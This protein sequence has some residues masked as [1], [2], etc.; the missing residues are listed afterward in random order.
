MKLFVTTRSMAANF[1]GLDRL[2]IALATGIG[3]RFV[4]FLALAASL[5][6]SNRLFSPA[7]LSSIGGAI[8]TIGFLLRP[9]ARGA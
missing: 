9:F 3:G 6:I 5:A 7:F 8:A 2:C 1:F 4:R